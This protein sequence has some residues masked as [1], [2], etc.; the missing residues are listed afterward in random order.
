MKQAGARCWVRPRG[1]VGE[2]RD[3]GDAR[4]GGTGTGV[5]PDSGEGSDS[6]DGTEKK[7]VVME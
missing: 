7:A 3:K 6:G 2:G 5:A 1:R 4:C